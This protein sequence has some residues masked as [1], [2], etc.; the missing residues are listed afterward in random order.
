[1]T[2][3]ELPTEDVVNTMWSHILCNFE[4]RTAIH[5]RIPQSWRLAGYCH[6][7]CEQLT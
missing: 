5:S 4:V 6:L 3:A 2:R 1:M 7:S